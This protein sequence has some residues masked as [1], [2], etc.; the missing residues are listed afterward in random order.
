MI[1]ECKI[2]PDNIVNFDETGV[3][4]VNFP[5]KQWLPVGIKDYQYIT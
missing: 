5:S 2:Q 3:I 4:F 1:D